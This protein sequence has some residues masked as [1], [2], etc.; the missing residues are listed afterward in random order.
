MGGLASRGAR[1]GREAAPKALWAVGEGGGA[2]RL[3]KESQ[4]RGGGGPSGRPRTPGQRASPPPV[5]PPESAGPL[6]TP[7]TP[8]GSTPGPEGLAPSRI[9]SGVHRAPS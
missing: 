8:G 5:S 2:L 7:L 1:R 9:P 4:P 3:G 6:R